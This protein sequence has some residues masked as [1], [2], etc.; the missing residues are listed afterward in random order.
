MHLSVSWLQW[1]VRVVS[2][3]FVGLQVTDSLWL[4]MLHSY[5]DLLVLRACVRVLAVV[6]VRGQL[7]CG[8]KSR[9]QATD[10]SDR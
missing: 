7:A 5:S 6:Y 2:S 10:Q 1:A 9:S 3:M 4:M 8:L